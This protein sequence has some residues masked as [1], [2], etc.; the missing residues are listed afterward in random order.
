[1]NSLFNES[2]LTIAQLKELVD[3]QASQLE[4][5]DKEYV[6]A[7]MYQEDD[8]TDAMRMTELYSEDEIDTM[9][10]YRQEAA[11]NAIQS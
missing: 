8:I 6:E 4:N 7:I 2:K 11:E 5:F 3:A 1:M 10:M 9:A